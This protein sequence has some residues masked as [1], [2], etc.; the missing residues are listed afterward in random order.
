MCKFMIN[1]YIIF[2]GKK[3]S[4]I[5][6]DLKKYIKENKINIMTTTQCKA[7]LNE[8][9]FIDYLD[10]ILAKYKFGKK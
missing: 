2:K 4:I 8:D 6:N 10:N 9:I 7:W 1:P 3:D 5:N